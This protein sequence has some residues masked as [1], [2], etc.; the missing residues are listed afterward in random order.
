M[1]KEVVKE[2]NRLGIVID[3]SHLGDKGFYDVIS[4]S[5]KPIVCSHSCSR[6][7]C[8][9]VRNMTDDMLRALAAKGGVIQIN[10]YPLFLDD[11]FGKILADSGLMERGEPIEASFIKDPSDEGKRS[12]WYSVIDDLEALPRPSYKRIADHIDHAVAV[13]GIDHVGIGSD[14]DGI[15]VTPDGLE[16][17]SG[18]HLIF[19]EMRHRGY[20]EED[21]EKVAGGNF[22][23]LLND[24]SSCSGE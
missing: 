2:M 10:F 18:M 13:A 16:D 12:A 22:L 9:H 24:V 5:T 3:C 19:D 4:L 21:I 6:S 17:I 14:F 1:N 11:A 20:S 8:N 23:R 7:V 15:E